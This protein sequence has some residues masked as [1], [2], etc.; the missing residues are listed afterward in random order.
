MCAVKACTVQFYAGTVYCL[1]W[2]GQL[3]AVRRSVSVSTY[4]NSSAQAH[5]LHS[6]QRFSPRRWPV[7]RADGDLPPSPTLFTPATKHCPRR[8]HPPSGPSYQ[9]HRTVGV[10][11]GRSGCSRSWI[12]GVLDRTTDSKSYVRSMQNH[13]LFLRMYI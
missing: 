4:S 3:G 9:R 2:S 11:E 10:F 6:W 12:T 8:Q 5:L 13:S 1:G 7:L